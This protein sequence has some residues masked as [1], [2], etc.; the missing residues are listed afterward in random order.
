MIFRHDDFSYR[1]RLEAVQRVHE[2]FL[3]RDLVETVCIQACYPPMIGLKEEVIEYLKSSTNYDIQLHCWQHDSYNEFSPLEIIRDLSAAMFCIKKIL[4]AYPTIL[5]PA[6]NA[7][8]ESV[9]TACNYLGLE[10]RS[11]GAYIKHY[12][13]DPEAYL[14]TSA[15]FFHSW[16][17]DNLEVLPVLLDMFTDEEV[18]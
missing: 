5:Y 1:T 11:Y 16:S 10:L 12:I 6:Y 4:G 9:I 18:T 3:K 14:G 15:I 13:G 17:E 8:S 2:E 7:D